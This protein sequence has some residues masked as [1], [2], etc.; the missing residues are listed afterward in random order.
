MRPSR[1]LPDRHAA[2]NGLLLEPASTLGDPT[3]PERT[4]AQQ[5]KETLGP[6]KSSSRESIASSTAQPR[7][8]RSLAGRTHVAGDHRLEP[9]EVEEVPSSYAEYAT[10]S[11]V[12][13]ADDQCH[14]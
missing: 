11:L 9:L 7:A 2:A 12:E 14:D 3:S 1:T 10:T 13:D 4:N 5:R 6:R 8:V